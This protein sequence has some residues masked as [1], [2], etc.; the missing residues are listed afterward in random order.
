M[1]KKIYLSE[2]QFKEYVRRQLNEDMVSESASVTEVC[3]EYAER[4]NGLSKNVAELG[5]VYPVFYE[6]CK[7]ALENGGFIVNGMKE[8]KIFGDFGVIFT[9]DPSNVEVPEDYRENP[10]DIYY[11]VA[12]D[13]I[14]SLVRDSYLGWGAY[15]EDVA[16]NYENG[17]VK[18]VPEVK[19]YLSLEKI[20]NFLSEM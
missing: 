20:Y 4:L 17:I 14:C 9:V 18:V 11:D 19:E 6:R 12:T 8:T 15:F 16:V 10:D 7:E 13:W 2:S 5:K 3:N 1:G